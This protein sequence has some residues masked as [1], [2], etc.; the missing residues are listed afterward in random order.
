MKPLA[1]AFVAICEDSD[2]TVRNGVALVLAQLA[3]TVKARGR[4]AVDA[5][6]VLAGLETS[7]PR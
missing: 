5:H 4:V 1:D 7:A 2:P 3:I 6:R